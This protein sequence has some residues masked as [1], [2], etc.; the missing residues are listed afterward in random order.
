MCMVFG[1]HDE[2]LSRINKTL[3]YGKLPKT[4]RFSLPVT[5]LAAEIFSKARFPGNGVHL[6]LRPEGK[7]LGLER[8][9]VAEAGEISRAACISPC[10][11]VL[12]LIYVDRLRECNSK[13]L[14]K[15]SPSKLFVVSMMV[16]SKF[17]HD[18]GEDDEVFNYEWAASSGMDEAEL[19]SGEREFLAAIDWRVSVGEHQFWEWL[20]SLEEAVA[21]REGHWKGWFTYSDLSYLLQSKELVTIAS[22]LF[23][24]SAVC[25]TSY[26]AG[27]LT[28]LGSTIIVSNLPSPASFL[29]PSLHNT[30]VISLNSSE[31]L[32]SLQEDFGNMSESYIVQSLGHTS[33]DCSISM[34][35]E[36]E[37]H[38]SYLY[39]NPA[40][41]R[42]QSKFSL[43]ILN[44][45]SLPEISLPGMKS[46][47][48]FFNCVN[49]A[50][51]L[52]DHFLNGENRYME[53][54]GKNPGNQDR[55]FDSSFCVQF[56]NKN[57][58]I[59]ENMCRGFQ[60]LNHFWNYGSSVEMKE[61]SL[62]CSG[63]DCRKPS[64]QAAVSI[65]THSHVSLE[66]SQY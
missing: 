59:G 58:I 65:P 35:N 45:V 47:G 34:D 54:L 51:Q 57:W 39:G 64:V 66:A 8:L 1:S 53:L 29:L 25:L 30:P 46:V 49:V 19:N 2:F 3:C 33:A 10:S 48:S 4:D 24:V 6:R 56:F 60:F 41:V 40:Y 28:L 11:L 22:T 55:M 5:E 7:V 21:F 14:E 9:G 62:C 23:T 15:T 50:S 44:F 16:A 26:T 27:V 52:F 37:H 12:A 43:G 63:Y 20:E 17:L 38:V 18:D 61:E 13:Y 32:F 42:E 31:P 36:L